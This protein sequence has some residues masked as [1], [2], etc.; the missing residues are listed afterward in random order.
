MFACFNDAQLK[1]K[2]ED[3]S[4]QHLLLLTTLQ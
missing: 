2:G 1:T 3:I 4:C